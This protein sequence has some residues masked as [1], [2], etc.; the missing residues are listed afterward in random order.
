MSSSLLHLL[1]DNDEDGY[2]DGGLDYGSIDVVDCRTIGKKGNRPGEFYY[3]R[4]V[5][6]DRQTGHMVVSEWDNNRI[7]VIRNDGSHVRFIGHGNGQGNGQFNCPWGLEVWNEGDLFVCDYNNKRVQRWKMESGEWIGSFVVGSYPHCIRLSPTGD[8]LFV[9]LGSNKIE[10]YTMDGELVSDIGF[11]YG[12]EDGQLYRPIGL[13]FNSRGDLF[14]GDG[15]NKR[16]SI[17]EVK[18]GE[19]MCNFGE[20]G[21]GWLH[22]VLD[23]FD[24]IIVSDSNNHRIEWFNSGLESIGKFGSKGNEVGQ[25]NDPMGVCIDE[26]NNH[27]IVCDQLNNRLKVMEV[28][29]EREKKE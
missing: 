7:Q 25:F 10:E 16:I 28:K 23:S 11:G 6:L 12:S 14:V 2:N 22:L 17:F 21:N 8:R 13:A 24:Q 29:K 20:F 3:P 9:S 15:K 26:I 4:D 1:D 18:S 5:V 27:L 19:W